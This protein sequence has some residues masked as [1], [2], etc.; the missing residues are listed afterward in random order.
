MDRGRCIP[1]YFITGFLGAGK[2]TLL[3]NILEDAWASGLRVDV[4]VNEWGRV[5]VDADVID[6]HGGEI[7]GLNNCQVFCSCL[8]GDFINILYSLMSRKPDAVILET[9]GM[10]NPL[11]LR[12]ILARLK[13]VTG[14]AYDYRGMTAVIDPVNFFEVINTVN[15]VEEQIIACDSVII[16]KMDLTD[17]ASLRA[18]H[19]KIRQLNPKAE[20]RHAIRGQVKGFLTESRSV[21]TVP[22]R[23]VVLAPF[24]KR[25]ADP[26]YPGPDQLVIAFEDDVHPNA[27]TT[28]VREMIPQCLRI[29]GV[30]RHA[31]QTYYVDGVNND[32]TLSP[33]DNYG[34]VP[35]LVLIIRPGADIRIAASEAWYRICAVSAEIE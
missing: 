34:A 23:N 28:F 33:I 9:S 15:V 6:A 32:V 20:I 16:N 8:Q 11:P 18:I 19:A 21:N 13:S 3:N 35:K 24:V 10:A 22:A 27:I 4:I 25:T 5:S 26:G 2:T 30:V 17:P 31:G 1:L 14:D 12:Q 29:K 7:V